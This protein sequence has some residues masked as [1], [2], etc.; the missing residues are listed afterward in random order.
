MTYLVYV[1]S[2]LMSGYVQPNTGLG[3]KETAQ[4]FNNKQMAKAHGSMLAALLRQKI[5]QLK[6]DAT[7]KVEKETK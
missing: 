4:R 6:L 1:N 2:A 5:G 7:Y 3:K